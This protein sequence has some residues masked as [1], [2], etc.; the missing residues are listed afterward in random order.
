MH[1]LTDP[2][3]ITFLVISSFF[4]FF[5]YK[6]T[7]DTYQIYNQ[8]DLRDNTGNY[9]QYLVITYNEKECKKRI[10]M[11]LPSRSSG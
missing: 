1:L 5:R 8:M 2:L 9:A 4:F 11:C 6:I 7:L 3:A 10:Y